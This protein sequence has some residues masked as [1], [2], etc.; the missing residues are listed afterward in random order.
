MSPDVTP[1]QTPRLSL[2]VPT[3]KAPEQLRTL[4]KSV[5]AQSGDT[6]LA[7]VIVVD[8]GTPGFVA[9]DWAG[10]A[11]KFPLTVLRMPSNGGRAVARNAGIRIARGDIVVFLDGDMTVESGFL[12]AHDAFHAQH[13]D[14]VAVGAIRWAPGLP[15]TPFMRYAGSRGVGRFGSGPVPY[16]CFVTGNSSVPRQLLLDTGGFDEG[17]STYGG[18]DLELGYRLHLSGCEVFYEPAAASLHFGWKGLR[19]MRESMSTYGAGSL[20]LLL[21]RHPELVDILRLDFLDKPWWDPVSMFLRATLWRFVQVPIFKVVELGES[22]GYVPSIGFDYLWW[23]ERTRAYLQ[24]RT[25]RS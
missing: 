9:D 10:M 17:F 22:L 6:A 19:G 15:D 5:A 18:E 4:L 12:Q 3:Y 24:S 16:R 13:K 21:E 2:V 8:D 11:G 1:R 25:L 23:S 14:A 7:E 20:P